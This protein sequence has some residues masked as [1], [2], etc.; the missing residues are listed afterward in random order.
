MERTFAFF[1]VSNTLIELDS[2]SQQVKQYAR[3]GYEQV[4]SWSQAVG[5]QFVTLIALALPEHPARR[6]LAT[7]NFDRV[8]RRA[9]DTKGAGSGQQQRIA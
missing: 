1:P 3:A 8:C 5:D 2:T 4:M 9:V 7:F 6:M